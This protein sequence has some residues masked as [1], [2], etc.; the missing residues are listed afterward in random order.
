ML[1]YGFKVTMPKFYMVLDTTDLLTV[2]LV[3]LVVDVGHSVYFDLQMEM[4]D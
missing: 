2:L 1:F 4:G 3:G